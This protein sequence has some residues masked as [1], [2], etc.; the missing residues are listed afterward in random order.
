[1]SGKFL[2]FIPWLKADQAVKSPENK[3]IT[4]KTSI[5]WWSLQRFKISQRISLLVILCAV[6]VVGMLGLN[7]WGQQHLKQSLIDTDQIFKTNE[8]MLKFQDHILGLKIVQKN[9]F[10]Y[11]G[12]D[13]SQKRQEFANTLRQQLINVGALIEILMAGD[14]NNLLTSQL[15]IMKEAIRLYGQ[16]FENIYKISKSLGL[17]N[18]TGTRKKLQE[19][20]HALDKQFAEYNYPQALYVKFLEMRVMEY[21]SFRL[22]E[23]DSLKQ[24][25]IQY[26]NFS[27]LLDEYTTP[28]SRLAM[29][30]LRNLSRLYL[31]GLREFIRGSNDISIAGNNLNR[32]FIRIEQQYSSIRDQSADQYILTKQ[33]FTTQQ[34]QLEKIIFTGT[35]ALL[36]LIIIS[37]L[38]I[39]F[40]ITWPFKAMI[41]LMNRLSKGETNLKIPALETKTE[42]GDMARALKVFDDNVVAINRMQDEEQHLREENQERLNKKLTLISTSLEEQINTAVY[43]ATSQ[44]NTMKGEAK[45]L[46]DIVS[47]LGERA[48]NVAQ[49]AMTVNENVRTVVAA[50]EELSVSINEVSSQ[51]NQ[52][53]TITTEAVQKAQETRKTVNSLAI[54]AETIG[55]I[56]N[57][58]QDIAEQTNLL[59][60]NATIEAARAGE[61]GKGFAVVASEVKSLANQTAR[62]TEEISAQISNIQSITLNAVEAIEVITDTV[63]RVDEI[64]GVI[65]VA[66]EQQASATLEISQN[67]QMA[68]E[69]TRDVSNQIS[70]VAQETS[71]VA[72]ISSNMMNSANAAAQNIAELNNRVSDAIQTLKTSAA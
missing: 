65:C 72:D 33:G 28:Q 56:V 45:K 38:I 2:K 67:V 20:T 37:A 55:K 63:N 57:L 27:Q 24:H 44:S 3:E 41:N 64:A 32:L 48:T 47:R 66:I 54:S 52:S 11:Q 29:T 13:E 42:I 69:S 40:S 35:A 39:A 36:V 22:K 17:D 34:A 16:K 50:A 31:T 58:I 23:A 60:L 30:T 10:A 26:T 62:A 51:V 18:E 1:M 59:A 8:A 61:A 70:E 9:F 71:E 68:A 19:A 12:Q 43:D 46:N 21:E 25:S 15:T 6:A 53:T 4:A 14:K 5:G 7:I 49:G